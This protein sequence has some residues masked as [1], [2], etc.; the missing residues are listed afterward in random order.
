MNIGSDEVAWED[1][2][3]SE[4]EFVARPRA[5]SDLPFFTRRR[6]TR[7][8]RRSDWLG[9]LRLLSKASRK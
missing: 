1:P 6:V 9:A 2:R 7:A 5:L 3:L 4:G 8:L